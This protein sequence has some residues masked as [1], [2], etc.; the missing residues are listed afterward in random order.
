MDLANGSIL[1]LKGLFS[2]IEPP[3]H[4][5]IISNFLHDMYYIDYPNMC[6]VTI[7]SD[8]VL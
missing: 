8:V 3:Q 1:S 4:D 2:I 5:Y 6:C 7:R